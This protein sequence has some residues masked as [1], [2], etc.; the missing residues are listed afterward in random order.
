MPASQGQAVGLRR[1]NTHPNCAK[2]LINKGKTVGW[3]LSYHPPQHS[4]KDPTRH[5]TKT[6]KAS[7]NF[8]GSFAASRVSVGLG[9]GVGV[10]VT[11]TPSLCLCTK[12]F[13][14][15]GVGDAPFSRKPNKICAMPMEIFFPAYGKNI[16]SLGTI[17]LLTAKQVFAYWMLLPDNVRLLGNNVSLLRYPQSPR[18]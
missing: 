13:Q 17:G 7:Y 14:A 16:P 12:A 18:Q 4:T 6:C 9:V 15:I 1:A 2:S 5:L 3:V 11:P 10:A 8:D